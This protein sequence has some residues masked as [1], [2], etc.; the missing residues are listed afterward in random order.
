ME[1]VTWVSPGGT[2]T[3]LYV[4]PG[5]SERFAPPVVVH[6]EEV[7]GFPGSRL[8]EVRHGPREFPLPIF[9]EADNPS[10][11]R[12][13]VRHLIRE[14]DPTFGEG[15]LIFQTPVGDLREI[16]CRC[17]SGLG[18]GED[19]GEAYA[20]WQKAV[21]MFKAF[22]PYFYDASDTVATFTTGEQATF[23][24]FFPLRLSAAEVFVDAHI[25]NNGDIETW[26]VW[27]ITG[28]GSDLRLLDLNRG[29]ETE[30]TSPVGTVTLTEGEQIT[31]DTRPGFKTV[32]L[33]DGTN[34]WPYLSP[35]SALFPLRPGNNA[36]RV[37]MGL[38]NQNSKVTVVYRPRYLTP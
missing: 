6:D 3:E 25:Q 35:N 20:T 11:L 4:Q 26:P 9:I 27:T 2:P 14:M 8:R 12:Q 24:P 13:K 30:L 7:P 18:L 21:P 17:I 34:L 37:E 29:I 33:S 31:I 10:L 28:P 15:K 1:T 22:D 36:I 32:T 16:R 5:V 23:F 19:T 38:A